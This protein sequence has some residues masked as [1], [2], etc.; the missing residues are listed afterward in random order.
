M[1]TIKRQFAEAIA[2]INVIQKAKATINDSSQNSENQAEIKANTAL[3]DGVRKFVMDVR[4]LDIDLIDR[5]NPFEGI[6]QYGKTMGKD[7]LKDLP[8]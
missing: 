1:K 5:I 2:A 3:I 4:D 6:C 7:S 8:K